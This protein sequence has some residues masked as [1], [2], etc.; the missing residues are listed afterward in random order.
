MN[1][2]QWEEAKLAALHY[3]DAK[4]YIFE[5]IEAG[6][7]YGKLSFSSYPVLSY[8]DNRILDFLCKNGYVTF[9]I[10]TL[11]SKQFLQYSMTVEGHKAFYEGAHIWKN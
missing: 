11:E 2:F 6:P 3:L 1:G 10:C 7:D 8:C 5:C 4:H 9:T